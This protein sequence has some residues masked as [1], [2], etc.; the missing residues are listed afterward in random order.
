[1]NQL[2]ATLAVFLVLAAVLAATPAQAQGNGGGNGNG[3]GL[4]PYIN[5][6]TSQTVAI[7]K[8]D[9]AWVTVSL[10][11]KQNLENLQVTGSIDLA[12]AELGYPANTATY[13]STYGDADLDKKETDY[14][15]FE[16]SIPADAAASSAN[17]N[18]SF[19]FASD[20]QQLSGTK[21]VAV[22][23]V[24]F[25]GSPFALT[26]DAVAVPAAAN[27]WVELP[28]AGLAPEVSDFQV[29]VEDPAGL[30][31]DYPAGTHTSLA[32]DAILEDGES[33]VARFRLGEAHWAAP[34]TATIR[35]DYVLA[36]QAGSDR[37]TVTLTPG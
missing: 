19:T 25:D 17:L 22:P 12:G 2:K 33:D 36:G 31:I 34:T 28:F 5:V 26:S 11:G 27:G 32:R 24:E 35:V 18:L 29:V 23:L 9:T 16:L 3:P 10:R 8:G 7:T 1:M 37:F 13:S 6:R 30:E 14:V 15:A 20:G 4:N 21:T